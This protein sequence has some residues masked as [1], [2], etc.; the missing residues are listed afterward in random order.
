MSKKAEIFKCQV[1]TYVSTTSKRRQ[2]RISGPK[3]KE[4]TL[5]CIHPQFTINI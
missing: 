3:A 5:Y 2:N 4:K 1:I